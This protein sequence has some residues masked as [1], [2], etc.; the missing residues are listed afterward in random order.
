MLA[1]LLDGD[2]GLPRAVEDFTVQTFIAQFA[3]EGLAVALF[4]KAAGR[5]VECPRA[6]LGEPVGAVETAPIGNA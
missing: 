2:G 6:E 3:V 4:P 1:L 5:N